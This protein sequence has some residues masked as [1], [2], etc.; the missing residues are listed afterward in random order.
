[1]GSLTYYTN[2]GTATA[3][4]YAQGDNPFGSIGEGNNAAPFLADL[5]GDGLLD[6]VDGNSGGT[7][8]YFLNTGT[9]GSPEYTI[10]TG[11][12]TPFDITVKSAAAV[13]D[14]AWHHVV[15]T[16]DAVTGDVQV[17]LDGSLSGSGTSAAGTIS[18][19][20]RQLGYLA[21]ES[22]GAYDQLSNIRGLDGLLDD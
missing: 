3:P 10:Q 15:L 20:F 13:N 21:D 1:L 6:L 4:V 11:S 2:T 9:A 16:R 14:G 7:L 22:P 8:R 19:A 17:Y 18:E 12:D 5:S